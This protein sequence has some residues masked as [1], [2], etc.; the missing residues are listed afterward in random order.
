MDGLLIR[1]AHI[2][3]ASGLAGAY[4]EWGREYQAMNPAEF[5]VPKEDGL[6]DYFST[7]LAEELDED[8]L[9]LVAEHDQR[10]VGYIQAQVSQP[11]D[12]A[13]RHIMR[14]ASE[15]LVKIDAL[16]VN[17]AARRRGIG[18]ALVDAAES[19]GRERGA[20]QAVV[21]SYA[22]SP[23]AVPFYEDQMR[24]SRK[25]IGFSKPL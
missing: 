24:Y 19:W 16:M 3:D 21:I 14:D 11:W 15:T 13:D 7:L 8:S 22:H 18:A 10:L 12:D 17:E 1:Q 5:R 9:W 6:V 23:T 25:T 2:D 20:T 4:A